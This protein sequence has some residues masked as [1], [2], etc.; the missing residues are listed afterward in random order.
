M[1]ESHRERRKM[2]VEISDI[3]EFVRISERAEECRVKRLEDL[4]KLKLRTP[5]KLYTIKLNAEKA[6]EVLK[7]IKC[8]VVET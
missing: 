2:P 7:Q 4:V 6:A 5:S 8:E 3:E 1:L